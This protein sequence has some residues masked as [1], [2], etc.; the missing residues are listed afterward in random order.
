M[1]RV[2][3]AG[4][5][6][7]DLVTRQGNQVI[8]WNPCVPIS[9]RVNTQH[10]QAG[11]SADVHGAFARIG[12]ASGISFRYAGATLAI[13]RLR[14]GRYAADAGAD[15]VIAW[16]YAGAGPGQSNMLRD[17]SGEGGRGG[18]LATGTPVGAHVVWQITAGYAVLSASNQHLLRSGFGPGLRR[19]TLLMHEL[20][21]TVG[22]LH[23]RRSSQV[24]Y[25]SV[26]PTSRG[27]FGS[28]DLASLRS[29]GR[30]AGCIR[31]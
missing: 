22:L 23:S 16:A 26:L 24:M 5:P 29:V 21:H 15:I 25:P 14:N 12:A 8:R 6:P 28:A 9:Y 4:R 19:G 3:P 1:G 13:P 10:A 31:G 11:A 2:K 7:D 18:W 30:P 27:T 20:G 17:G